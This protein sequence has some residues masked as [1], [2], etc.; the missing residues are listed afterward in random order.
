MLPTCRNSLRRQLVD[1]TLRWGWL[2]TPSSFSWNERAVRVAIGVEIASYRI[3][4]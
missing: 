1:L 2:T 3:V 4:V